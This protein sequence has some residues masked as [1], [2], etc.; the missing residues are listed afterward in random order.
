MQYITFPKLGIKTSRF[1]MGCMRLPKKNDNGD[2]EIIN[3]KESIRMIKYAIDCGVNY[4]DTAYVYGDS[5]IVLGK[6]LLGGLREKVF[7]AT[8]SPIFSEKINNGGDFQKILDEELEK[9]QT[10]YIDFYLL[11][12]LNKE[13]WRK[14]KKLGLLD[15]LQKVKRKNKIKYIG[16]S[17]HDDIALFKE[18]I[19]SYKWD[20][21]QIQFNFLGEKY[22][23]GI[24]GLKYAAS[25][26]IGVVVMEPLLGG[27]IIDNVSGEIMD[28]WRSS[29]SIRTPAEWAFRWVAD[30]P[31]V[32]VILSGVNT[33]EQLRENIEIFEH[34]VPGSLS[35]KEIQA[36]KKVKEIY[37]NNLKVG[38]TGCS[39]CLPCPSGVYIP[40]VFTMY[41]NYFIG[42]PELI[43]EKYK[44]FYCEG[45]IDALQCSECGNCEKVCPQHIQIIDKLLEAHGH[46]TKKV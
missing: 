35:K 29:G 15:E 25:K 13:T 12:N 27:L 16:F 22:Q 14:T 17:F 30:F 40:G 26:G 34:A 44:K 38:C 3:E 45:K 20:M 19:D 36:Y 6:A 7:L 4:F 23:A 37:N 28:I 41:N 1:G 39:Y 9:L 42:N 10:D 43:K 33:V 18:I 8:K 24:K 21:C 31:E 46:L 5:E 32:S 11:H 2:N